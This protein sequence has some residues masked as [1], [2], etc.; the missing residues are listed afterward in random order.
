MAKNQTTF[1]CILSSCELSWRSVSSVVSGHPSRQV[2]T[3]ISQLSPSG[4]FTVSPFLLLSLDQHLWQCVF[5]SPHNRWICRKRKGRNNKAPEEILFELSAPPIFLLNPGIYFCRNPQKR[6]PLFMSKARKAL[7]FP[8][9]TPF[10]PFSRIKKR[11]KEK[12]SVVPPPRRWP[13]LLSAL[14]FSSAKGKEV[15]GGRSNWCV[16]LQRG[17]EKRRRRGQEHQKVG[18]K[19]GRLKG[20]QIPFFPLQI[21][22]KCTW[23]FKGFLIITFDGLGYL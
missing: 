16:Y 12:K 5:L 9:A 7:Y 14:S 3:S 4:K 8:P 18:V 19:T 10:L 15:K 21:N 17:G 20:N 22:L 2:C 11:K 6:R 23:Q 1:F 13:H